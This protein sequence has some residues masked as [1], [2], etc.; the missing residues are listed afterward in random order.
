MH[1]IA[2]RVADTL[3]NAE[4]HDDFNDGVGQLWFLLE[5]NERVERGDAPEQIIKELDAMVESLEFATVISVAD[6]EALLERI[7]AMPKHVQEWV[8]N[9]AVLQHA[10]SDRVL[11]LLVAWLHQWDDLP[12]LQRVLLTLG[13][14]ATYEWV[15]NVPDEDYQRLVGRIEALAASPVLDLSK[16]AGAAL[17]TLRRLEQMPPTFDLAY[18][19][20]LGARRERVL[21]VIRLGLRGPLLRPVGEGERPDSVHVSR[22]PSLQIC[23]GSMP[24][25]EATKRLEEYVRR[26]DEAGDG[27]HRVLI[28]FLRESAKPYSQWERILDEHA[29]EGERADGIADEQWLEFHRHVL[30]HLPDAFTL[31]VLQTLSPR[32]ESVVPYIVHLLMQCVE[33]RAGCEQPPVF[34]EQIHSILKAGGLPVGWQGEYPKG[35]ALVFW[36]EEEKP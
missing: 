36:P 27:G 16:E 1:P 28:E 13:G 8:A 22:L 12:L 20:L 26:I 19:E 23:F 34:W 10:R 17:R 3:R 31:G 5:Y 6:E 25:A 24:E 21:E 9:S 2:A 29:G 4:E 33:A 30:L 35:K 32:F 18:L 7:A 14:R 11:D 15:H